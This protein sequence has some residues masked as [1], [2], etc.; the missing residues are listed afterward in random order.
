[1][2]IL[3][4]ATPGTPEPLWCGR[5]V[6][7]TTKLLYGQAFRPPSLAEL[8]TQNNPSNIGNP[9]LS[10]ETME[11]RELVFDYQPKANLRLA[12][13]LFDHEIQDLIELVQDSGQTTQTTQNTGDQQ[14]RGFELEADWKATRTLL[15]RANFAYQRSKYELTDEIVPDAPEYQAYVHAHWEPVLIG[16]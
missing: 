4:S 14:G 10:P 11:S 2:S 3:I 15:V 7:L 1:M 12:L 5:P 13:S 9:D 16:P 6:D 8:Y